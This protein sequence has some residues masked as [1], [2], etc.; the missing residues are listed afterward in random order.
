M[1]LRG[2]RLV[3]LFCSVLVSGTMVSASHSVPRTQKVTMSFYSLQSFF[4]SRDLQ[5]DL[6]RYQ[7][8]ADNKFRVYLAGSAVKPK[9]NECQGKASDIW[10]EVRRPNQ[11]A[12]E[13]KLG[14]EVEF[15]VDESMIAGKPAGEVIQTKGPMDTGI[16]DFSVIGSSAGSEGLRFLNIF[17]AMTTDKDSS[18]K[19]ASL[20]INMSPGSVSVLATVGDDDYGNDYSVVSYPMLSNVDRTKIATSVVTAASCTY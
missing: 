14:S 5:S 19:F 18:E 17:L 8:I 15:L 3:L 13:D 10:F 9:Q 6:L 16:F 4:S 2:L 7:R 12:G 11:P 20:E 1:Y